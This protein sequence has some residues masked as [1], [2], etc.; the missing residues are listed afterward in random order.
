MVD[1]AGDG[2]DGHNGHV[3]SLQ[4]NHQDNHGI[5]PPMHTDGDYTS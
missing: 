4:M 5:S 2:S 1:H 3:N